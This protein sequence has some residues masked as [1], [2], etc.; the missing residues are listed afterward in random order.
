[1]A[2]NQ[3]RDHQT[4]LVIEKIAEMRRLKPDTV[5]RIIEGKRKNEKVI[6]DYVEFH[7]ALDNTL[8]QLV[9]K[10]VPFNETHN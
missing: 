2:K 9:K 4:L 3:H 8:I 6:G 5:T 1:M 7:Q 10:L